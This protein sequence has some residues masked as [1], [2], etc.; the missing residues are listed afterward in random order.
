MND[1]PAQTDHEQ[2]VPPLA[3]KLPQVTENLAWYAV[4]EG[5]IVE[6][7]GT[8]VWLTVVGV[9]ARRARIRVTAPAGAT[10]R[11]VERARRRKRHRR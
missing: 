11:A 4:G 9:K 3:S 1:Q 2:H 6:I 5:Q 7:A 8:K 10:F